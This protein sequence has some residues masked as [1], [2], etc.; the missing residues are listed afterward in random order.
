MDHIKTYYNKR[1]ETLGSELQRVSRHLQILGALRLTVFLL[2]IL[3]L[4]FF[5]N[6]PEILFPAIGLSVVIFVMLVVRFT[7]WKFLKDKLKALQK[8]VQTELQVLQHNYSSLPTGSAFED[9]DHTYSG[10]IEL[11]GEDSFFQYANR[12]ALPE[13]MGLLAWMLKENSTDQILEKQQA[14]KELS[15]MPEWRQEYSAIASLV[16]TEIPTAVLIKWLENFKPVIPEI[17]KRIPGVFSGFTLALTA[18][19]FL[20]LLS[21]WFLLPWFLA[22]LAITGSYLKKI[23]KL[24]SD[25]SKILSTFQQHHRLFELLE[26]TKFKSDLL[27]AETGVFQDRKVLISR[28]IKEF[29]GILN[30]FDQRNNMIFGVF[31]NGFLLW[32]LWNCIRIQKWIKKYGS[33]VDQWFDVIS[34]FDAMNSLG[35]FAF[36]HP[37]FVFPTLVS[38]KTQLKVTNAVHPLIIPDKR[39]TNNL[40]LEQGQFFIVTGAN[41]AGKSTFLRT[42]SLLILMAN[43]GLPV[44]ASSMEYQPI[45][46]IT[47]MRTADSLSRQESYFFSEL[48]RL[49]F[50]IE[51]ISKVPYLIILDE[52]LKGTNSTD[53]AVGSRKFIDKLVK[54]NSTGIIATHDLSLCQAAK[55][56]DAVENYYFEASIADDEL[57][58]DYTLRPGICQNMNASFLLKKMKIID[59]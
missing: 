40:Y 27:R 8:I 26:K 20:D 36:N 4:Y 52:I 32:D 56:L 14:I 15:Q 12:T 48:K 25:T 42:V 49:K 17:F 47:S 38:G 18:L 34:Y 13:G 39:V 9:T 43:T 59:Q 37:D 46:L 24:N 5:Y 35:N 3:V 53:K 11:F 29:S 2:A 16:K 6:R 30:A 57:F 22:G 51:E 28:K 45:R 44:C 31:G 50:I 58:F 54:T 41:M 19:Y 1:L 55:E 23:N 7:H 33:E 21:G 10:D